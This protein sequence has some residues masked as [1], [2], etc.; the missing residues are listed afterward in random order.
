MNRA[1]KTG[2]VGLHRYRSF[3][4]TGIPTLCLLNRP[5]PWDSHMDCWIVQYLCVMFIADSVPSIRRWA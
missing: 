1:T 5:T 3:A 4:T 2:R